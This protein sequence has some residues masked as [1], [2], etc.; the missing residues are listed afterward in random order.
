MV[1]NN[2][3]ASVRFGKCTSAECR[4]AGE[5]DETVTRCIFELR[6]SIFGLVLNLLLIHCI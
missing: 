5:R 2:R 6:S 1:E 3:W 4:L